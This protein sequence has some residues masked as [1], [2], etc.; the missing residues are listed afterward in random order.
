[1]KK[2]LTLAILTFHFSLFTFHCEA[3]IKTYEIKKL[4]GTINISDSIGVFEDSTKSLTIEQV[5]S[6]EFENKFHW[7]KLK[8]RAFA[9]DE[10]GV[11]WGRFKLK[12]LTDRDIDY[13]GGIN[14]F[15][16][17]LYQQTDSGNFK[18]QYGG[19]G[20]PINERTQK[21]YGSGQFNITLKSGEEALFY[22]CGK[23]TKLYPMPPYIYFGL[24][25]KI[26]ADDKSHLSLSYF[27]SFA[28][29]EFM[30]IIYALALFVVFR[31]KNY[32][33][34]CLSLASTIFYFMEY[35]GI[36]P[37]VFTANPYYKIFVTH[38][39]EG[40]Y[41]PLMVLGQYIFLSLFLDFKKHFGKWMI[42]VNGYVLFTILIGPFFT[43]RGEMPKYV[44]F[45]NNLIMFVPLI[46]LILIIILAIK[47]NP[48]AKVML[49][50]QGLF[51]ILVIISQLILEKII[52]SKDY[53]NNSRLLLMAAYIS[54]SLL[55][56]FAIIYKLV[57]LRKEKE[58]AQADV[59]DALQ[60]NE[61]LITDQNVML[62]HKVEE[63][64]RELVS[65]KKKSDD[66]L[67]NILPS[68]VAEELKLKGFADAK[69]FAEA[70]VMFT[71]FK[72]FTRIGEKLSPAKLVEEI[73]FCFSSFDNI[74]HKH[75]IEKIKTIGDAYMCAGGLPV[76]NKTHADDVV[77]A[78]LEI[79]DFMAN[80]NKE[81][82]AKGELPFEIR[83]GINTGPV[84]AGIVGV[85]KFAYDIWGDTVNLASR[86]ESSGEAGKVNISGSTYELVKDKFTCAHRGKIQTKNKG[87][88][89]MYFLS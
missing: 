55:W 34:L 83:I 3:R 9:G 86:M 4:N 78:A 50:A 37:Y 25:D 13:W 68:E 76:A 28:G 56:T 22:V 15:Y 84:V 74:I 42:L 67:L 46:V 38:G 41:I 45:S 6:P 31:D 29:I 20:V 26:P 73:H 85:K 49:Y 43:I 39:L 65:E 35:F 61:K 88:V 11:V 48:L 21:R 71:D 87:E 8:P 77:K 47:R 64:T 81:K 30:M 60:V 62:E 19:S 14:F 58:K 16:V 66:L 59:I 27:M 2:N 24:S 72:D 18:M 5:A 1:M 33:W 40:I 63:R 36:A 69:D 52:P 17:T 23:M 44:H 57:L 51:M 75:G 82:L 80:H 89:D 54:Q 32:L 70:T 10:V 79:R 7:N 53:A 12:N